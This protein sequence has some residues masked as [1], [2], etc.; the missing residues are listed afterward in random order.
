MSFPVVGQRKMLLPSSA[1]EYATQDGVA[2]VNRMEQSV[3]TRSL[4][5]D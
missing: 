3:R 4:I 5:I 1:H 2:I